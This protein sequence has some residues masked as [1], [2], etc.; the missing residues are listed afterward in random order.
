VQDLFNSIDYTNLQATAD[1]SIAQP[2]TVKE[3]R[4]SAYVG[5]VLHTAF[6]AWPHIR[7][8]TGTGTEDG[9][10]VRDVVYL[11]PGC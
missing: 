2:P 3:E 5:H 1:A 9:T 6:L 11:D 4:R 10:N 7:N 8:K